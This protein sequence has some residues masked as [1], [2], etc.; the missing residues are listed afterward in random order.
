[1]TFLCYNTYVLLDVNGG[2]CQRN[3]STGLCSLPKA[4]V[5]RA[6]Q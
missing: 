6:M 1:M 5:Q 2:E 4:G 3:S